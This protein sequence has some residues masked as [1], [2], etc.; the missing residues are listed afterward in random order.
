M[1][2]LSTFNSLNEEWL[3]NRKQQQTP[4]KEFIKT[5]LDLIKKYINNLLTD[6]FMK[7]HS[8]EKDNYDFDYYKVKSITKV[9]KNKF[10]IWL[11]TYDS[12]YV[13]LDDVNYLLEI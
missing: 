5:S 4:K 11:T 8:Q 13:K 3:I 12:S 10:D 1:K 9:G 6:D 2:H 7:I